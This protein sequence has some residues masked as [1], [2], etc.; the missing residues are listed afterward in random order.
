MYNRIINGIFIYLFGFTTK[1]LTAS[2]Q[3]YLLF[4]KNV[5]SLKKPILPIET[6]LSLSFT[7]NFKLERK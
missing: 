3:T 7:P 1:Q 4:H 6:V 2:V 5:R